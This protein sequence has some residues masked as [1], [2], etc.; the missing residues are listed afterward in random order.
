MSNFLQSLSCIHFIIHK[1][2][3][4]LFSRQQRIPSVE[5]VCVDRVA[6][7]LSPSSVLEEEPP[8]WA[9]RRE[10]LL[11]GV[12]NI[13]FILCYADL[14]HTLSK[15]FRNGYSICIPNGFFHMILHHVTFHFRCDSLNH[16]K[17]LERI[18]ID[19]KLSKPEP[20]PHVSGLLF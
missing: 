3:A 2:F 10:A 5:R 19:I 20:I 8:S 11:V 9:S 17:K 18:P 13:P 6:N 7:A 14:C 4:M 15:E 1:F 12:L 16:F